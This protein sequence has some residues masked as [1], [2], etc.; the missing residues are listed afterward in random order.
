MANAHEIIQI[1]N[2]V[3]TNVEVSQLWEAYVL[4]T[5]WIH[6]CTL[7]AELPGHTEWW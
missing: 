7:P 2:F 1:M 4:D 6:A 5:I 3:L